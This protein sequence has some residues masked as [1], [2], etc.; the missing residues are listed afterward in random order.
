MPKA[1][2]RIVLEGKA[3]GA[4]HQRAPRHAERC[5]PAGI[6]AED[7]PGLHR[8]IH[9]RELFEEAEEGTIWPSLVGFPYLAPLGRWRLKELERESARLEKL[10]SEEVGEVR[11][12]PWWGSIEVTR[13]VTQIDRRLARAQLGF[14]RLLARAGQ[15]EEAAGR[16]RAA[17]ALVPEAAEAWIGLGVSLRFAGRSQEA[18][19]AF[20][21]ALRLEPDN[22]E[23]SFGL[24]NLHRAREEST[25][26]A[27]LYRRVLEL[28][29][30]H[31][32]SSYY[33]AVVTGEEPPESIPASLV[34]DLFD[35]YAPTYDDHLVEHLEYRVPRLLGE[36][37]E[38]LLG[39]EPKV[40]SVMDLGCGTGLCGPVFR[41][42]ATRLI[43]VDLSPGMIDRARDLGV[44][45]ELRVVDVCAALRAE[46]AT[47]D[48]AVAADLVVYLG[49]LS[50]L[51]SSVGAALRAGGLL[52]FNAEIAPGREPY[53]LLSG[54]RYAHGRSYVEELAAGA[55]LRVERYERDVA[56]LE[57]GRA[58]PCQV[59]ALAKPPPRA[60][61][62]C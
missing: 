7:R 49:D 16:F 20:D 25:R 2:V 61:E 10:R 44:Y 23:A 27:D 19:E 50:P 15:H 48:L 21:R 33:L 52:L 62:C 46:D 47:I 14:G 39:K 3:T 37:V 34:R 51:L 12:S 11:A 45:D 40:G 55:G 58:V 9:H 24:A 28:D 26:A 6:A 43:G 60:I 22:V 54:G 57:N 29:P 8:Q 41:D 38:R 4:P 53:V 30:G 17:L 32:E 1:V 13:P 59:F 42:I 31:E 56:R 5:S 35:A 18:L 36:A